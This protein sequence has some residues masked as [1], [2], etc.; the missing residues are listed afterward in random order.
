MIFTQTPPETVA[1]IRHPEDWLGSWF[2]FRYGN[3]LDGTPRSTKGKTFD[4]FVAA[5]LQD[6]PPPFANVGSQAAFLTHPFND[7]TV[8][9][10]WRYD[11]LDLFQGWIQGELGV[12]VEVPRANVSPMFQTGLSD[13][14]RAQLRAKCARDYALYD[15]AR[16]T[17]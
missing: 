13:D 16:S 15:M 12:Q 10:L 1:L 6:A 17:A 4:E 9:N 5:Y 11:A 14:L 7:T 3:W 8:Q 2:R